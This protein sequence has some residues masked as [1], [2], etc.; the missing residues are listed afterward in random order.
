MEQY[1]QVYNTLTNL[2]IP[3]EVVEHPPVFTTEEADKWII[4]KEGVRSKTLLLT[5]QKK[6][7][8]YLIVM[9]G[10]KRLDMVHLADILQ[11][12]RKNRKNIYLPIYLIVSFIFLWH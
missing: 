12:K 11:E 10:E 7:T 1:L 3:Y 6:S 9:D 4:G 2:S 5:N 8:Y